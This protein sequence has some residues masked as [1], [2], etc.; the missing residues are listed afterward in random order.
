M[1]EFGT[2]WRGEIHDSSANA[3]GHAIVAGVNISTAVSVHCVSWSIPALR[4]TSVP[5][6]GQFFDKLSH[7]VTVDRTNLRDTQAANKVC[8]SAIRYLGSAAVLS[9]V[10]D[11]DQIVGDGL[12]TKARPCFGFGPSA[13]RS[14]TSCQLYFLSHPHPWLQN[15]ALVVV[16]HLKSTRHHVLF[17]ALGIE[18]APPAKSPSRA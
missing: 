2:F 18:R 5:V 10:P 9:V 11:K 16:E 12:S 13:R 17:D 3:I 8:A 14:C 7:L 6:I 1:D 4:K 15:L